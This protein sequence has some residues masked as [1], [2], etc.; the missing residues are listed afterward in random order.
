MIKFLKSIAFTTL[1]V[2]GFAVAA[3]AQVADSNKVAHRQH[4]KEIHQKMTAILTPEQQEQL[5]ADQKKNR[6]AMVAFKASLTTE[7]KAIAKDK[8]LSHKERRAKLNASFTD[9]QKKT[10][11]DHRA[12]RKESRKAFMASLNSD[13]KAKMKELF[14]DRKGHFGGRHHKAQ[15]A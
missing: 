1:M 9:S 8:S 11:A 2:S 7:Q 4:R 15:K 5:K 10:L 6:Q 3:N 13:Q 12:A 14:K